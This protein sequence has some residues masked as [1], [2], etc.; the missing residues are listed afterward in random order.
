MSFAEI[1]RRLGETGE[2]GETPRYQR[3]DARANVGRIGANSLGKKANTLGEGENSPAFAPP[4]PYCEPAAMAAI[5][6]I[7]PIRP[8]AA[9][10]AL[11]SN[12]INQ[13]GPNRTT[14]CSTCAHVCRSGCCGEPVAAGLSDQE[15]VIRYHPNNG[16]DC[17]TWK[18]LT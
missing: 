16:A 12:G 1:I 7:R 9:E 13:D 14:T 17:A 8:E 2:R 4:S 5:S 6:P 11:L 10:S 15:G 3:D 18:E